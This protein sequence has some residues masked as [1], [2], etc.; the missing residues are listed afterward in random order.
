MNTPQKSPE[1]MYDTPSLLSRLEGQ[2]AEAG[3]QIARLQHQRADSY[4]T[5]EDAEDIREHLSLLRRVEKAIKTE[6]IAL[7][8]GTGGGKDM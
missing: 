2:L 1:K 3:K 7:K 8:A 4:I 6:L 5:N